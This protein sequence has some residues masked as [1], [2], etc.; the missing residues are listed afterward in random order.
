MRPPS[1]PPLEFLLESSSTSLH[2]LEVAS[3]N[4]ASNLGKAI[5]EEMFAWAE[6][7]AAAM[8]ARW[9]IENR[10]RLLRRPDQERES[11]EEFESFTG[12]MSA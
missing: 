2:D 12:K 3:L 10:E 8:M 6:Q 11:L 7:C 5:R 4:R 9:M 1:L